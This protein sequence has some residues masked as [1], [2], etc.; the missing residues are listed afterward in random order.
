MKYIFTF[1]DRTKVI[2]HSDDKNEAIDIAR[3][4]Q[5]I[6]KNSMSIDS[7]KEINLDYYEIYIQKNNDYQGTLEILTD[8][9]N[10]FGIEIDFYFKELPDR[11]IKDIEIITPIDD[12]I[13]TEI[14]Q[15]IEIYL[16]AKNGEYNPDQ[17][18][19]FKKDIKK[20]INKVL[21]F[22]IF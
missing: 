14:E 4:Q 1:T 6:L 2:I 3:E 9:D 5:R 7:V 18:K 12:S 22:L 17:E 11:D 10:N 15:L 19:Y 8:P 16:Y 13:K 20:H 21:D